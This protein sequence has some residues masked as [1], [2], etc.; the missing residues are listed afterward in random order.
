MKLAGVLVATVT[1]FLPDGTL[2]REGLAAHLKFLIDNGVHGLVPCGTT[3]ESPTLT[4]E[5][6]REVIDLCLKAA[7]PLGLPVIAGCGSNSTSVAVEL[8]REAEE[9]GCHGTLIVTPYYNRPTQEGLV[10]HYTHLAD[11]ARKPIVLYHIPIRTN[12]TMTLETIQTLFKHPQI[13]GIKEASDAPAFWQ[14]LGSLAKETGKA[15]L[16]GGDDAYA[17]MQAYGACGTISA[18]ANILPA[19]FVALHNAM[20][21]GDWSE[22]FRLQTQMGGVIQS[23]FSET[24]PGP[25]KYVLSRLSHQHNALRLPLVPV[26]SQTEARLRRDWDVLLGEGALP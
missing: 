26:R 14:S 20:T 8:V 17:T 7:A 22:A 19:Q 9:M 24:N 18:C 3:G 15:L 4:R 25:I 23:C 11:R 12:V 2:D 13:T 21:R 16:C 1:P 10:A 6:R 5:D